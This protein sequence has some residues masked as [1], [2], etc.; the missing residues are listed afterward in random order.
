[1]AEAVAVVEVEPELPV[2]PKVDPKDL[3]KVWGFFFFF[4]V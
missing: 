2:A 4:V 1:M 3:P